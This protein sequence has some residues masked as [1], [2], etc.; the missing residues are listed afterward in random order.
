MKTDREGA[1]QYIHVADL[2]TI[3]PTFELAI[4][5]PVGEKN[6]NAVPYI[7]GD[8]TNVYYKLHV[9][10]PWKFD[11]GTVDLN[12]EGFDVTKSLSTESLAEKNS[13]TLVDTE[14]PDAD[15]AAGGKY[16]TKVLNILVPELGNT[17]SKIWDTV[18]GHNTTKRPTTIDYKGVPPKADTADKTYNL[19][20]I[21]G[22]VNAAQDIIGLLVEGKPAL[23]GLSDEAKENLYKQNLVYKEADKYYVI[24][25]KTIVTQDDLGTLDIDESNIEYVYEYLP[26]SLGNGI[27]TLYSGIAQIQRVL[28][29]ESADNTDPTTLY[30]A[31]NT[32]EGR[33]EE[34][35]KGLA[36][37]AF[38]AFGVIADK[39]NKTLA[40]AKTI[41]NGEVKLPDTLHVI[42]NDYLSISKIADET[43][44]GI[45]LNLSVTDDVEEKDT[46]NKL[47]T[48][49]AIIDSL[50]VVSDILYYVEH[51]EMPTKE[52]EKEE[53]E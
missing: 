45:Q 49:Q 32:V 20:T 33:M 41:Q 15:Y 19:N 47:V 6:E 53:E 40:T 39:D 43:K 3:V 21:A 51:G 25:K 27:T 11:L 38:H 12:A 36:E 22:C 9:Q 28:G 37:A 13:V 8:S 17:I 52:E 5:A 2:N 10:A 30:G 29:P 34:W 24:Y 31:L 18:Y 14:T 16:D 7:D 44:R 46:T 50:G 48:K 42:G 4:D 1:Q 26:I 23:D 35:K